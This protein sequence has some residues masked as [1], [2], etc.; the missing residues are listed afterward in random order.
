MDGVLTDGSLLIMPDGVMT[1][2]MNIKDGYALRLAVEKGYQMSIISGGSSVEVQER[3]QKLGITDVHLK[4]QDKKKLLQ[5]LIN[6]H[7]A[8]PKEILY[9]GDDVPD[10]EVMGIVGLP[11]CPA[12][13]AR[14]ILDISA[15]ISPYNGGHGCV[16]D[17]IEKVLRLHNKWI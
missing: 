13:A 10:F 14:D 5:A 4:V 12:D 11:C 3:L 6:N 16:R 2:R 17:V 15:Y 1:R 8:K 7:Q 9:M